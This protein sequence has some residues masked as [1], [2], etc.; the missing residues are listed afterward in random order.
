MQPILFFTGKTQ[1]EVPITNFLCSVFSAWPLPIIGLAVP[2]GWSARLQQLSSRPKGMEESRMVEFR[3]RDD[4]SRNWE[5]NGDAWLAPSSSGLSSAIGS[6]CRRMGPNEPD[7]LE[8]PKP[9]SI[10][11][12]EPST[13]EPPWP[14]SSKFELAL[15]YNF[16]MQNT[17][18]TKSQFTNAGMIGVPGRDILNKAMNPFSLYL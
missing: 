9:P 17:L 6:G 12:C 15:L 16:C 5:S 14:L 1:F 8:R 18:C 13:R 11:C 10:C 3:L 7:R 4:G 2:G